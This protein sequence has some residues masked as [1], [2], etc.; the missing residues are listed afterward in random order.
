MK[1]AVVAIMLNEEKHIQA[2]LDALWAEMHRWDTITLLDTG[3]TDGTVELVEERIRRLDSADEGL[4][5][6]EHAS[7]KPWRFDTARNTALALA[8]P[9]ADMVWALDLDE[10][11]QPG[12]R[13]H[14]EDAYEEGYTRLRYKFVWSQQPDGS[15]GVV[16]FADKLHKRYGFQWKGIAHEWLVTDE[17]ERHKWVPNLTVIHKQD[18]S[19][20]RLDRDMALMERAIAELPDDDR[21]QHYYAR[22]LHF[23]GRNVE[24]SLAFQKHLENPKA[25]WR[26]E[27]AESMMYLAQLGGN[28]AWNHQWLYR[29]LA[30]SPERRETWLAVA[31]FEISRKNYQ[32]AM[33]LLGQALRQPRDEIYLSRPTSTDDAI[34]QRVVEVRKLMYEEEVGHGERDSEVHH[35]AAAEAAADP[36]VA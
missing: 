8:D 25:T 12:W 34:I 13:Q 35:G 21:L 7:I 22:Q 32:A 24:A 23:V 27:R 26:A 18:H 4:I 14:I 11:P 19:V 17:E 5:R 6:L 16:F 30:E 3:S 36:E 9:N 2:W 31:E 1:L 15:D 28:E 29:A 10:F 33:W 20:E